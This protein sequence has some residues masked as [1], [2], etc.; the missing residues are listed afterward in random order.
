MDGGQVDSSS[1]CGAN[2]QK[3]LDYREDPTLQMNKSKPSTHHS[4]HAVRSHRQGD[5]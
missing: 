2:V 3:E 4:M 5:C 1:G